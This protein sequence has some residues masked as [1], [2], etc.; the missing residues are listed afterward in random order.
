MTTG[1]HQIP[2]IDQIAMHQVY[3]PQLTLWGSSRLPGTPTERLRRYKTIIH[4]HMVDRG[5]NRGNKPGNKSGKSTKPAFPQFPTTFPQTFPHPKS[6]PTA[7][8]PP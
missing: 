1:R 4:N 8:I 7:P 5:Y 6:P 3:R 2:M